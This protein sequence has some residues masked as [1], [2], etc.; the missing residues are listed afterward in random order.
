VLRV[1]EIGRNADA[2]AGTSLAGAAR[3]LIELELDVGRA[4]T[5]LADAGA[6]FD[7]IGSRSADLFWGGALLKRWDGVLDAAEPLM[8][9]ALRLAREEQDRWCEC[10][11]HAWLAAINFELG[12]PEVSLACCAEL[13]PLAVKMGESGG[14]PFVQALE[15]LAGL[16]L[17]LPNAERGLELAVKQLEAFD[18]KAHLAY[19][20]NAAA[21][22]AFANGNFSVACA[23]AKDALAAAE[24]TRRACDAVTSRALLARV[25]AAQ[26]DASGARRWLDPILA[27]LGECDGLSARARTAGLRAAE[28]LGLG[29]PTMN[30][31]LS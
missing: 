3:C 9:K 5:L 8:E 25:L 20:L 14:M 24:A 2:A 28:A 6:I 21:E 19:V 15:A 30:Q 27:R 22:I 11:C 1:A 29:I 18:S 31:T 17:C 12:K 7:R 13:R 23:A 4:R 10:R 26:G 16:V